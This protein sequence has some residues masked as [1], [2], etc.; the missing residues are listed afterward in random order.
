MAARPVGL[1]TADDWSLT[2][3][4][5]PQPGEGEL[6]VR[7]LYVSLDPAMRSWISGGNPY[8]SVEVGD[9]MLAPGVGRVL[10]SR[11]PSFAPGDHVTGQ[12]KVQTHAVSDGVGVTAVDP[13]VAPLPV[14]LGT[15]GFTGMTAYFGMVDVGRPQAG[16]TVAVSGAAGATGMVAG[17]IAKILGCRVVGIAGGPD[18]CRF[19]VDEL[20][21]DAAIDYRNEKVAKALRTH[22]PDGVDV[23]FDNVGGEILDAVLTRLARNARVVICGAVSQYN[24]DGPMRGPANY[25]ALVSTHASMQGFFIA[26]YADRYPEAMAALGGWL[27]EGRL[28]TREDVVEGIERFPEALLQL[29]TGGNTGKLVLQVGDD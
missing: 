28:K 1:P 21:F 2:E 6:L 15:L 29:Y 27:A 20:G 3:A 12:F 19:L 8:A 5:I 18:K 24:N 25:M 4:P 16:Q 13:A 14:Y 26:N 17:Q 22:C 10:A 23:F 9:V 7:V 11:H